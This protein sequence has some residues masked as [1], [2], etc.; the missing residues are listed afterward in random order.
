MLWSWYWWNIFSHA[1]KNILWRFQTTTCGWYVEIKE[2][3][4]EEI[5]SN[6]NFHQFIG[7]DVDGVGGANVKDSSVYNSVFLFKSPIA[8]MEVKLSK[9]KLKVITIEEEEDY[10]KRC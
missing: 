10:Y 3:R 8:N 1:R 9:L 7:E 5:E 4:L 6:L 2:Q